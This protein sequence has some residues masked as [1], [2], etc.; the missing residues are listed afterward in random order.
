MLST[1]GLP[2]QIVKDR[3]D[4]RFASVIDIAIPVAIHTLPNRSGHHADIRPP[5]G[6]D[7]DR[8]HDLRLAKPALSQ[9]SY[10]PEGMAAGTSWVVPR[11]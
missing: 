6:A 5:D 11:R 4:A 7:G 9:L 3:Y 8:T 1:D 10:S 2:V